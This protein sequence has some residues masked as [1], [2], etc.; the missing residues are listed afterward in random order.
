MTEEDKYMDRILIID[1][2][3]MFCE[4]LTNALADGEYEI[5]SAYTLEKGMELV[6]ASPFDIVFL[7]V[8]LPDGNGLEKLEA[9]RDTPS[10]PEV[11]ILTGA[12][13]AD[14]AELA[15]KSGAWDY[16]Q[17]PSSIT[18]M[19]LPLIRALQYRKEKQKKRVSSTL[20]LE[21]IIGSSPRMKAC[22]DLVREAAS[23]NANV[24][25]TGETGTGKEL[26]AK[27]IHENSRCVGR[28]FVVVDCAALQENLLEST[29]FGY[30]KGAFTG[31]DQRRE[32]LIKQADGGTLFLDEIGELSLSIQKGFL[33]VLQERRF[34]PL[35][36]A[37]EMDS[38]FRLIVATNR[39]LDEMAASSRFRADLL[40]R[41]R[42][43]T[44][45]LPPLRDH[46]DDIPEIALYHI[47]RIC[48]RIGIEAKKLSPDFLEALLAYSWPGNIR[49]LVHAV[50]RAITAALS[51]A[52]LFRKHLPSSIRV[53]L[54]QAAADGVAVKTELPEIAKIPARLPR[55]K[56]LRETTYAKVEKDYLKA[57][58]EAT[59]GDI[60][61][62][63]RIS[64]LSR[65]RLYELLRKHRLAIPG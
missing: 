28:S 3:E 10:S 13:T 19:T 34:R 58:L 47:N 29:L 25:V 18:A 22:Y 64:D 59:G 52:T 57:L 50:E 9:I 43:M 16:I 11:I 51:G 7:D 35:G 61:Q 8:N 31:A 41:V 17:K 37:K 23:S 45:E 38:D 27:A 36:S 26:F 30:E 39:K 53:K 4:L 48:Q 20:K 2:D 62:A 24:L 49:E 46:A 56:E 40:F 1:D 5:L 32:G 55:L 60:G 12:G 15:I 63:C 21:G 44:I 14:G 42:S 6:E 54:A 65:T 33:R